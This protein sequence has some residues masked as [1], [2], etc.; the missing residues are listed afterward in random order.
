M[1]EE[2]FKTVKGF[3]N[4]MISNK[5]VLLTNR[6]NSLV[7]V[8]KKLNMREGYKRTQIYDIEGKRTNV[9]IHRLVVEAF[10]GEIKE[11][12]EVN[13]IDGIRNNNLVTNLEIVTPKDN[14]GHRDRKGH[15]MKDRSGYINSG[16]T[17]R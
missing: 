16:G 1:M 3:P 7:Y 11:G 8:V 6:Q 2:I 10:I 4:Y 17:K 14:C 13:H 12:Y 15:F 5:G 9:S